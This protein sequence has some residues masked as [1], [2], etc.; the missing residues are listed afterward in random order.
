MFNLTNTHA[1]K[2]DADVDGDGDDGSVHGLGPTP[3]ASWWCLI[4]LLFLGCLDGGGNEELSI[5]FA[6]LQGSVV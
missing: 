5:E 6:R 3:S 4:F 2:R 1:K